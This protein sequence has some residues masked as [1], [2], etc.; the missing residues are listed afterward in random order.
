MHDH[1]QNRRAGHPLRVSALIAAIALGAAGCQTMTLATLPDGL[2]TGEASDAETVCGPLFADNR[3]APIK[4]RM[5]FAPGEV[6]T[7]AMLEVADSPTEEAITAIKLVEELN[8]TCSQMRADAG[9]PTSAMEDIAASRISKL[10]YG[11]FKG[12]IPYGVYNYGVAQVMRESL[13]FAAEG[14]QAY[15][16]GE[17][18]GKQAALAQM[19]QMNTQMQMNAMQTQVNS[20]NTMQTR[21]WHCSG[22]AG[23]YTCY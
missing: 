18:I 7:R 2:M 20:Y 21:T 5:A 9:K 23:T 13:Q 6:P 10:R 8:R 1:R 19:Q 4:G 12:E 14:A 17:E 3:L 11:L 15:A 22:G 16:T